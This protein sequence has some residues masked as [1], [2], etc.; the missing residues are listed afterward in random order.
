MGGICFQVQ[1]KTKWVIGTSTRQHKDGACKKLFTNKVG[2]D[3]DATRTP[4]G[5]GL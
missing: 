2:S 4:H 1:P 3:D 5:H